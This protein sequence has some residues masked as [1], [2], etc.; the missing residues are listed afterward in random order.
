V[1][2][3]TSGLGRVTLGNCGSQGLSIGGVGITRQCLHGLVIASTRSSKLET[4]NVAFIG[5]ER[6][7][8][9]EVQYL[10]ANDMF[11]HAPY[12]R[13]QLGPA[14]YK[15]WLLL[16]DYLSEPRWTDPLT[17]RALKGSRPIA[18]ERLHAIQ[19]FPLARKT[20][21]GVRTDL[22]ARVLDDLGRPIPGLFASGELAGM[23]GGHLA[24]SRP[25]EGIMAGG[26]VFSGRVAA[27]SAAELHLRS[28][29]RHSKCRDDKHAMQSDE[30]NSHPVSAER[31]SDVISPEIP[32]IFERYDVGLGEQGLIRICPDA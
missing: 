23:G 24:G 20:L 21:G 19:F 32:D 30:P 12:F 29:K 18:G 14:N 3:R 7:R 28:S 2:K 25:L 6:S 16:D 5:L 10:S 31:S 17:G 26:P 4:F 13:D 27:R 15:K 22:R 9:P 1:P 8:A 11:R